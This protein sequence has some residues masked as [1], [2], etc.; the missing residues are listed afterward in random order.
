MLHASQTNTRPFDRGKA[1]R[2]AAVLLGLTD[3]VALSMVASGQA[4][5]DLDLRLAGWVQD[6]NVA[7]LDF[8]AGLV[9]FFSGAPMAFTLWIGR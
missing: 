7:G 3:F 8:V 2:A 5:T 9:N 4:Y 1:V 6:L